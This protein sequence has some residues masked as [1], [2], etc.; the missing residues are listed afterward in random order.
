[1]KC[2]ID[3]NQCKDTVI[4]RGQEGVINKQESFDNMGLTLKERMETY[5]KQIVEGILNVCK[6]TLITES[7]YATLQ[8]KISLPQCDNRTLS[9]LAVI[10]AISANYIFNINDQTLLEVN[11][12]LKMYNIPSGLKYISLHIR[13]NDKASE[14]SPVMFQ[15]MTNMTNYVEAIKD[16]FNG[17]YDVFVASDNCKLVHDLK[18]KIPSSVKLLGR[19]ISGHDVIDRIEDPRVTNVNFSSRES[20]YNKTIL[21]LADIICL[22]D[23]FD[24]FG[25]SSSNVARF[26]QR[27]RV[28]RQM[29][30]HNLNY[31][32]AHNPLDAFNIDY[33]D[34]Y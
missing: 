2:Y 34:C 27:I 32:L 10:R 19:C 6:S 29:R 5:E 1:M 4:N 31:E 14:V 24:F 3:L 15:Y 11:K 7:I 8:P 28:Y 9:K 17:S 23:G 12:I 25:F 30:V 13:A 33:N 18:T 21:L 20:T 26:V 22:S 16:Y